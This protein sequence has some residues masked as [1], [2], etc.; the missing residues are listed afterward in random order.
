MN[1]KHC[2][3]V[4]FL[5]IR[6]R[7]KHSLG[8]WISPFSKDWFLANQDTRNMFDDAC[9]ETMVEAEWEEVPGCCKRRGRLQFVFAYVTLYER[10]DAEFTKFPQFTVVLFFDSDEQSWEA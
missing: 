2:Y 4:A 8:T 7:K 1:L 9:Y 3:S 5:F 6:I 10:Q